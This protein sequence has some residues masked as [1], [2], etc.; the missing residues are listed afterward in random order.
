MQEP[1][2]VAKAEAIGIEN[3]T[4][5]QKIL[6]HKALKHTHAIAYSCL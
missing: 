5:Q 3:T 6:L 1:I 2:T 4:I